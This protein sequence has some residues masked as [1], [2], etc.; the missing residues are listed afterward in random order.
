MP[1]VVVLKHVPEWRWML[2]REDSP[3]YPTA[4]LFRQR[5]PGDWDEVFERIRT[6]FADLVSQRKALWAELLSEI[7]G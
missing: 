4:R 1:V 7:H 2:E 3:W 5:R 6:E